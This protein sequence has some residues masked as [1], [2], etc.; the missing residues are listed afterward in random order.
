[1]QLTAMLALHDTNTST[2]GVNDQ[3]DVEPPFNCLDLR[4]AMLPLTALL[5]SCDDNASVNF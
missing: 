3:N 2:N 4:N 5:A 1:M